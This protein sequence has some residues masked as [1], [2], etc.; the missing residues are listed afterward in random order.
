MLIIRK[1][2]MAAFEG[3]A[4][5]GFE[6]RMLAHLRKYF[7]ERCSEMGEDGVRDSIRE[8]IQRTGKLGLALEYDIERYLNHMFALGLDFDTN[9]AYPWVKEVLSDPEIHSSALMDVL[10]DRTKEELEKLERRGPGVP[11]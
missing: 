10:S 6:E 2:Q 11:K 8:A 1:E 4:R 7:P 9:P 3:E 5:R